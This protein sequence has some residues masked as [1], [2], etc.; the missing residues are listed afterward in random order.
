MAKVILSRENSEVIPLKSDQHRALHCLHSFSAL[1][2][3]LW[4]K[5]GP[6]GKTEGMQI[7]LSL[8]ADDMVLYTREMQ[9][10]TRNFLKT[11]I[12]K[13]QNR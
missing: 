2:P 4:Q 6:E 3:E 9:N 10:S 8:F 7:Q 12:N 11:I 5:L 13:T 1:C